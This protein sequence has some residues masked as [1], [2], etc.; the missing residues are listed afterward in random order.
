MNKKPDWLRIR[1]SNDPNIN[2]VEEVIENLKLNTVCRE[3]GC[4]NYFECFSRKTATFLILGKNCTRS[5][6]FCNV[7]YGLPRPAD[8]DEPDNI[9]RAVNE[10]ELRY[11]VITSVTRDDL[12]DGGAGHFS[13]VIHAVRSYC[14]D[15]AVE[16][17]IPDFRGDINS[18]KIIADSSPDVIAHNIETVAQLYPD[19]R[20]QADY[21][22]SLDVLKNIKLLNPQIR[23]KTGIMLGLGETKAQV[24]ELFDD[25]RE[26]NCEFLTVGQYL[27]PSRGHY[28]VYEYITP[29]QFDE[30]GAAAKA[31][32]FSF[33]ASAP[34]VRSS[35]HAGDALAIAKL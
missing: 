32:G 20:P 8:P 25:L 27:A 26:A 31:G 5:C 1:S 35:Y 19:V 2:I 13:K 23:S 10:L 11:V 7:R 28:P 16:V 22:R 21:R 4:P 14:R 29:Q 30:Y 18:L 33:V 9:A 12:A 3:A 6:R 34:L 24:H 15:T 17:L